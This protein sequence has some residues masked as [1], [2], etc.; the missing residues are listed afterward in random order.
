MYII[1]IESFESGARPALQTWEKSTV[2]DGYA[3]CPDEFFDVFYST[4]PSGF[5]NITVENDTVT[6]MEVNWDAYNA[7][8]AEHPVEPEPE[9]EP[10]PTPGD[11]SSVWDELDAAYQEGVDSV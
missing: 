4:N 9:P 5:V 6:A 10:E 7:Y 1:Q 11:D 3:W 2:P 8:I